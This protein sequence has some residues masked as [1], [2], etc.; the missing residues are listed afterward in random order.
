MS[1]LKIVT[2]Q[3]ELKGLNR[4]VVTINESI[5]NSVTCGVEISRKSERRFN[6][7]SGDVIKIKR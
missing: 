5:S 3:Q 6:K 2:G 4:E 1:K 7:L